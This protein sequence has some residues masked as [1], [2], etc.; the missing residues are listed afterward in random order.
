[1]HAACYDPRAMK[2]VDLHCHSRASD[3]TLAPAEVVRRGREFG[4]TTLALTDHDDTSGLAEAAAA[5]REEGISFVPG[6]EVSITWEDTTVHVVGLGID[7]DDAALAEGLRKVRGGRAERAVRIAEALARVGVKGSLEGAQRYVNN[8]DLISRTHFARYLVEA[9]HARDF[10]SV[11]NNYLAIGKP[12]YVR[13]QWAELGEAL[14][15]I[16]GAGGIPVL[17]HPARYSFSR[18]QLRRFLAEF[19]ESGGRGIEV[20]TSNHTPDECG[21][22]AV[23]AREF[24]LLASRGSDFHG[25]GESRVEL[26]AVPQLP[27][28]LTP[29]WKE[30]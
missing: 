29:V 22:F 17:A 1:M 16:G 25:P 21:T 30:L 3:G 19:S 9:G 13:H 28:D 5:A 18:P 7:P 12:G 24:G 15:W 14:R 10:R 2:N 11:F 4:V 20:T 8:P 27:G 23:L 6:V 26:G